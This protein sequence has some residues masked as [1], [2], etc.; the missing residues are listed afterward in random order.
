MKEPP[1]NPIIPPKRET[2]RSFRLHVTPGEANWLRTRSS[3]A[4]K[5]SDLPFLVKLT[6]VLLAV[7][8][9]PLATLASTHTV[10]RL[11]TAIL[12]AHHGL[13]SE[14]YWAIPGLTFLLALSVSILTGIGGLFAKRKARA[15]QELPANR[16]VGIRFGF[17]ML[18]HPLVIMLGIVSMVAP[19]VEV[20][21]STIKHQV[22]GDENVDSLHYRARYVVA[23]NLTESGLVALAKSSNAS[24]LEIHDSPEL[25][26]S[27][28]ELLARLP[29]L[30]A[31]EF[32]AAGEQTEWGDEIAEHLLPILGLR[33]VWLSNCSNATEQF[34]MHLAANHPTIN[35]VNYHGNHRVQHS[36]SYYLTTPAG[37]SV[38]VG[39]YGTR[40]PPR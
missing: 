22:S 40:L 23:S 8:V 11:A 16:D 1:I 15:D 33:K 19:L 24:Y 14:F 32:H 17:S 21:R 10:G 3:G 18:I 6:L 29:N 37:E 26:L 30:Q 34:G 28:L 7:P 39:V 27:S 36:S 38:S 35:E 12:D 4:R 13:M 2:I 20:P 25:T 31:L 9:I 5:L